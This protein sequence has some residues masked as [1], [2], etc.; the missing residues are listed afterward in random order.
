MEY[1]SAIYGDFNPFYG[2]YTWKKLSVAADWYGYDW[3]KEKSHDA[4]A[5]CHATL[6]IWNRMLENGDKI[7]A[8]RLIYEAAIGRS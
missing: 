6:H 1:F 2:S 3:G 4:L 5:D 7:R 8:E